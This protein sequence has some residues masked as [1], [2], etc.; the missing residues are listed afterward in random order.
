MKKKHIVIIL[1]IIGILL[2]LIPIILAIMETVNT[3][4][5]GGADFSTFRY[6]FF[7]KH[8]RLYSRIAFGGIA[9]IIASIV[10]GT[11][12]KRSNY[13]VGASPYE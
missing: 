10:I 13:T 3:N 8:S 12:K 11:V 2:L 6:V 1:L 4:I 5:I 7:S 9:S